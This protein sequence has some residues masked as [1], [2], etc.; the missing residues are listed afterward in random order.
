M[1]NVLLIV[2]L[3]LALALIGIVLLQRSEGA[4]GLGMSGGNMSGRAPQSALGRATWYL[5]I[6][7]FAVALILTVVESRNSGNSSV[8]D[9]LTDTPAATPAADTPALPGGGDLL[10]PKVETPAVPTT[11]T[12]TPAVAT[13][14]ADAPATDAPATDAPATQTPAAETPATVTPATPQPAGN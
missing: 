9:R 10:P 5:G 4:G 12:E 14:A 8:L 11:T 1:Q 7:F 6:A 13:P 2:E 3:L